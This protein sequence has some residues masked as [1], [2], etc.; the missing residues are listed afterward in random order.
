MT[1]VAAEDIY[2]YSLET[3]HSLNFPIFVQNQGIVIFLGFCLSC[4]SSLFFF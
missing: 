4:Y 2:L 1:L 3:F